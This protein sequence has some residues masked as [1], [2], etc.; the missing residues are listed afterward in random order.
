MKHGCWLAM[1]LLLSPI[2]QAQQIEKVQPSAAVQSAIFS[3]PLGV[4]RE[5]AATSR[6]FATFRDP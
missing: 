3:K 5:V 6:D 4:A 1:M 2:A